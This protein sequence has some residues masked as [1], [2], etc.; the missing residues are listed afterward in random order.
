MVLL[1]YDSSTIRNEIG[2]SGISFHHSI[3]NDTLKTTEDLLYEFTAGMPN[4]IQ[5]ISDRRS[6]PISLENAEI[7]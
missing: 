1:I 7:R 4:I 5:F 3:L 2:Q 6:E